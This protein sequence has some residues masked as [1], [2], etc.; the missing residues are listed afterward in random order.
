MVH[1][2]FLLCT[3]L[4][5]GIAQAA[6]SATPAPVINQ[7]DVRAADLKVGDTVTIQQKSPLASTLYVA[8]SQTM[9]T[10]KTLV[11]P[12]PYSPFNYA[13]YALQTAGAIYALTGI[14]G[15]LS[16]QFE[17]PQPTTTD[18]K[19]E[20]KKRVERVQQENKVWT[21][22]GIYLIGVLAQILIDNTLGMRN[23]VEIN[24]STPVMVKLTTP[25]TVK[26]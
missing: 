8:D 14:A 5:T 26:N 24:T 12:Y 23:P 9:P 15:L 1:N 4:A 22:F 17:K 20:Q 11:R 10:L 18:V 13:S 19:K 16:S 6:Q 3:L 25:S 7:A 21:G 2:K